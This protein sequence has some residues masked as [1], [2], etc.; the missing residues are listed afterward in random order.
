M[1]QGRRKHGPAFKVKVAL[2]AR[3]GLEDYF[4]SYNGLRPHQALGY[5][6]PAEVFYEVFHGEQEAVAEESHRRIGSPEKGDPINGR[7]A[8]T[9][10]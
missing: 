6:T 9:L 1:S 4:R 5:R 10:N 2:E 7:R 8:W 3:K